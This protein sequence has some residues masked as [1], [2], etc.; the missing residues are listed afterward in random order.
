VQLSMVAV[1]LEQPEDIHEVY[2]VNLAAFGRTAEADLVQTLRRCA[3]PFFSFVAEY[4]HELVGHV[5]FS[6]VTIGGVH[7]GLGLAPVA[8]QPFFQ[9]RGIGTALIN[10][11]LQSLREKQ[12]P[13]LVVLGHSS[14]YPRF[15]FRPAHEHGIVC[16]Y[17]VSLNAFM[18]R[19]LVPNAL[20][21][22]TGIARYHSAFDSLYPQTNR[23]GCRAE[24]ASR[25][26]Y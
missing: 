24:G 20:E 6:P 1:P 3:K 25:F 14:Y 19:E 23:I 18:V 15:G 2:Q 12:C 8:V 5:A 4:N 22:V 9:R 10:A 16:E 11:S 13:S 26:L 17:K 21:K 7:Q